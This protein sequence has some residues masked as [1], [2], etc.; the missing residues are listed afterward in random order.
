MLYNV[1]CLGKKLGAHNYH[2]DLKI[3]SAVCT[4]AVEERRAD[5]NLLQ[6]SLCYIAAMRAYDIYHS[7]SVTTVKHLVYDH[8]LKHKRDSRIDHNLKISENYTRDKAYASVNHTK[9]DSCGHMSPFETK[10]L[11]D[12]VG[13]AGSC[14]GSE[15]KSDARTYEH[16]SAHRGKQ[17]IVCKRTYECTKRINC[18]GRNENCIHCRS[19]EFESEFISAY[20][21]YR[22]VD[23]CY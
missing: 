19:K 2:K 7:S 21:K 23:E 11:Y 13:T 3:L 14:S 1:S 15:N 9:Y 16:S 17:K 5:V 8:T 18:N 10:K 20:D 22:Y 12:N 6:Q 4:V